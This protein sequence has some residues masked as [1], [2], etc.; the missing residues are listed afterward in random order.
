MSL[1][2]CSSSVRSG[3]CVTAW[4]ALR[5]ASLSIWAFGW[6]QSS[7]CWR[8]KSRCTFLK[9]SV[10]RT[11]PCFSFITNFQ[12]SFS[13]V[14]RRCTSSRFTPRSCTHLLFLLG[15]PGSLTNAG[16]HSWVHWALAS[17][18]MCSM[19]FLI[20]LDPSMVGGRG[21]TPTSPLPWPRCR[22]QVWWALP[23]WDR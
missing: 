5:R 10:H 6:R 18:T 22:S 4:P 3:V 16:E 14:E 19:R 23:L 12:C 1:R 9:C 21:T 13:L 20:T 15:R 7:L 8:L 11:T 2:C 17:F